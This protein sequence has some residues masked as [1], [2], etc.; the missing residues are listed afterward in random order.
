MPYVE[1]RSIDTYI[2]CNLEMIIYRSIGKFWIKL[3]IDVVVE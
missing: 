2:L 3:V 1:T